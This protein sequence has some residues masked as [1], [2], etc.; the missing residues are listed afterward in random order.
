M[1][2]GNTAA[3]IRSRFDDVKAEFGQ[4]GKK[5]KR[6]RPANKDKNTRRAQRRSQADFAFFSSAMLLV[7]VIRSQNTLF[8]LNLD[9]EIQATQD[10][11]A[12]AID[13][14]AAK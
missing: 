3:E 7:E 2:P 11:V 14:Q 12:E 4:S 5:S 9:N 13:T 6:K 8:A 1:G 10:A